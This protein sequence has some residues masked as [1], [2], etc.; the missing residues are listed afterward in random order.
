MCSGNYKKINN[1]VMKTKNQLLSVIIF[2]V[3]MFVS[4]SSYSN[5]ISIS[6]FSLTGQNATN[7]YTLIKFDISWDNSWRV[8][9]PLNNWDAARVFVKYC[10]GGGEWRQSW[11]NNT[12]HFNPSGSTITAGL[13]DPALPFNPTTNPGLG[14]FIYRDVNGT[15]KFSKSGVQLRWNYGDNGVDDNAIIDIRVYAIKQVYI[16][17]GSF[18]L[19]SGRTED[20]AFY[21]YPTMANSYQITSED[22]IIV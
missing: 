4:D 19:G 21:K 20:G 18:D 16:P 11:L 1:K 22:A 8:S 7:H 12:G 5:N 6:N 3:L 9:S 13:L 17:Q 2:F 15:G 10:I 14:V